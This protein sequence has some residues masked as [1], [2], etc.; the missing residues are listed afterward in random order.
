MRKYAY[1]V[2]NV[3]ATTSAITTLSLAAFSIGQDDVEGRLAIVSGF[4]LTVVAFKS[5]ISDAMP[6]V[7]YLTVLD[8]FFNANLTFVFSL[9][10][11]L[12]VMPSIKC[13]QLRDSRKSI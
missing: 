6:K 5:A 8:K 9:I 4:L 12:A 13:V 1:F 7:S 10:L 3:M 11:F 2:K